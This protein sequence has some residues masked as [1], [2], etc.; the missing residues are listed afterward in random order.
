[1]QKVLKPNWS[2]SWETIGAEKEL[3]D[4][5]T[6]PIATLEG[7]INSDLLLVVFKCYFSLKRMCKENHQL[8]GNASL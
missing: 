2:A 8:Y 4:T 1:M 3:E 7:I 5:Y 6:L